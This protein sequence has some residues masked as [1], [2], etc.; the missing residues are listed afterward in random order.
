MIRVFLVDD[1]D[2]VR[3]GFRSFLSNQTDIDVVG[4]AANAE[5]ALLQLKR[6]PVDVLV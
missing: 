4:D 2:M 1:H 3:F 5:D 6:Q